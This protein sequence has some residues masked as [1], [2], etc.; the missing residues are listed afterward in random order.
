[1]PVFLIY[2]TVPLVFSSLCVVSCACLRFISYFGQT[3]EKGY[4]RGTIV[5]NCKPY[6]ILKVYNAR[7]KRGLCIALLPF[8]PCGLF[9]NSN[10]LGVL[11]TFDRVFNILLLT[12]SFP[13]T[14]D[15]DLTL[16][17]RFSDDFFFHATAQFRPGNR[18]F[19]RD[20]AGFQAL[21][22]IP[23]DLFRRD[24]DSAP[25]IRA[26]GAD[27][28]GSA[29]ENYHPVRFFTKEPFY[30]EHVFHKFTAISLAD[31]IMQAECMMW[32]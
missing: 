31:K 15:T 8:F 27:A 14:V 10:I 6:V 24:A 28:V 5:S 12:K 22:V 17:F 19:F 29:V 23:R 32:A 9:P 21:T 3:P 7:K 11:N 25:V 4:S 20:S 2:F 18:L 26:G 30:V 13:Q 1:M 16:D